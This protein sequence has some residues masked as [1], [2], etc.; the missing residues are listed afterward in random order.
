M[1]ATRVGA[2]FVGSWLLAAC[3]AT[4]AAAPTT[5][6]TAAMVATT[7]PPAP[8]PA[9]SAP[10]AP[11]TA[12]A[13]VQDVRLYGDLAMASAEDRSRLE[14][15]TR[16]GVRRWAAWSQTMINGGRRDAADAL[17][18]AV[19][20]VNVRMREAGMEIRPRGLKRETFTEGGM[21][22]EAWEYSEATRYYPDSDLMLRWVTFHIARGDHEVARMDLEYSEMGGP[23]FVL[24]G[25]SERGHSQFV[26]YGSRHPD[27]WT[28]RED[29]LRVLRGEA[30]P[31]ISSGR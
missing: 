14:T 10:P 27:Y 2:V 13:A 16:E 18:R 24:G 23:Y 20:A 21:R 30:A 31:T 19:A 3:T 11:I 12:E 6:T 1:R 15:L 28:V 17:F 9:A 5:I 22:V 8:A 29:A 26:P 4:R 25:A 7:A